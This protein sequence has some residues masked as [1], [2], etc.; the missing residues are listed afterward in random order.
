MIDP[1]DLNRVIETLTYYHDMR[2]K[3]TQR[4]DEKT[5]NTGT[6]DLDAE[7][8]QTAINVLSAA[9]AAGYPTGQAAVSAFSDFRIIFK[10]YQA[11][12]LKF[13]I[14]KGPTRKD[15]VWHCPECNRRVQINTSYCHRC[16]KK[17]RWG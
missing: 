12:H 9:V 7:A 3:S 5:G 10:R 13:E 2:L 15:G 6:R 17:L 8:M 11:M 4:L 16:G 1:I 14:P